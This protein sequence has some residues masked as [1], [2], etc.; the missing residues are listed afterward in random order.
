MS[1]GLR[2]LIEAVLVLALLGPFAWLVRCYGS[3]LR[4]TLTNPLAG[5]FRTRPAG[6]WP[7]PCLTA[8]R[9]AMCTRP[10]TFCRGDGRLVA[11]PAGPQCGGLG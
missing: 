5:A 7:A 3:Q 6:P 1:F 4:W 10:G 2:L 8:G 11:H 9:L